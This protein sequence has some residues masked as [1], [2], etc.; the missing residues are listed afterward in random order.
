MYNDCSHIDDVHLLFD[1]L[2]MNIFSFLLGVE[3]RHFFVK[4]LDV[5]WFVVSVTP[6]VFI[7]FP[8]SS[9]FA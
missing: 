4:M 1:E 6:K 5:F 3:L 2:F 9:N 7:E 8:F